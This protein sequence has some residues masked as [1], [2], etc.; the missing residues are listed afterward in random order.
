MN[1]VQ[2]SGILVITRPSDFESCVRELEALDGIEVHHRDPES[3]RI[4]VVQEGSTPEEHENKL[5]G[6]RGL[7]HVILAELVYHLVD[8]D[9]GGAP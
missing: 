4:I 2:Y 6:I 9:A 8:S 3:G 5:I 1:P 7:P